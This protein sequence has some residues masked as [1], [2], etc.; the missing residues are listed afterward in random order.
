ML[1]ASTCLD[2]SSTFPQSRHS[3]TRHPL[4]PWFIQSDFS[5]PPSP[6]LGPKCFTSLFLLNTAL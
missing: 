2:F 6:H 3:A 4:Q 5:P 1:W